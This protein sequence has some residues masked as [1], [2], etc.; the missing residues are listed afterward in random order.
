M[1]TRHIAL[2]CEY[3]SHIAFPATHKH[4][5]FFSE[6]YLLNFEKWLM[7]SALQKKKRE[8]LQH[9][10]Q[11]Y[12]IW[13]SISSSQN[14]IKDICDGRL[15][16]QRWFAENRSR[17]PGILRLYISSLILF[18]DYI[19][20]RGEK[21]RISRCMGC[22]TLLQTLSRGLRKKPPTKEGFGSKYL[23][24]MINFKLTFTQSF[25]YLHILPGSNR[26]CKYK[27]EL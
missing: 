13:Q 26:I 6:P 9:C 20:I 2:F 3:T 27:P 17:P 14:S 7:N 21:A 10:S 16:E 23:V 5:Y 15:I 12:S 22:K 4:L 25:L 24:R 1:N 19:M 11:V 8:S 18:V